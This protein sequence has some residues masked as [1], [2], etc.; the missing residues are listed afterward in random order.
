MDLIRLLNSVGKEIFV[1][2]YYDFKNQNINTKEFA[3]K[4]L[5]ENPRA[6][7]L[8]AQNTRIS[9]ARKIFENGLEK[10]ALKIIINSKKLNDAVKKKAET[11]LSNE[12]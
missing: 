2:Y 11:I 4:L 10:D 3:I 8:N 5:E 7:S 6:N 9:K 12:I 1:N